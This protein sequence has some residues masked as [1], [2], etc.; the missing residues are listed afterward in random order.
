M[1]R[2]I[3]MIKKFREIWNYPVEMEEAMWYILVAF[4]VMIWMW[5][6]IWS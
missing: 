1:D 6:F 2:G 4:F 5:M 3:S